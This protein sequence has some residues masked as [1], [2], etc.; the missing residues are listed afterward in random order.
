MSSTSPTTNL[1]E[2]LEV[3]VR[4]RMV[5]PGC[6][7]D[8]SQRAGRRKLT[9]SHFC[10]ENGWLS[11]IQAE[12]LEGLL[13]PQSIA[14]GYQIEGLLG[15]GGIGIVY[16]ARQPSL[17]RLVALKTISTTHLS[18]NSSGQGSIAVARFQQEA[19][20]V[21]KLKHPNIVTAYDY[22]A[23]DDR[24]FL[25]MEMVEGIDLDSFIKHAELL[26]ELTAWRIAAQVAA[27]LTH[28][29][30]FGVVHRDIKPANILATDPS[31][32]HPLP[33]GTPLVKVT[34]FGLA[35]LN[36]GTVND[37]QTRLTTVGSM[38]GTPH[39]M[40]PEQIENPD[41]GFQADIYA[42]GATVYHMLTGE[43]PLKG[44]SVMKVFVAKMSGEG[45]SLDNLPKAVGQ[46]GRD[47]L[48]AMMAHDPSQ[49][50][51]TYGE[52]LSRIGQILEDEAMVANH[53][54]SVYPS[55]REIAS[56]GE[57][58]PTL[59][60]RAEPR[61]SSNKTFWVA[62]CAA[63]LLGTA[64]LSLVP[65]GR[66]D[67]TPTPQYAAQEGFKATRSLY[68]GRSIAG[69]QGVARAPDDGEYAGMLR[70]LGTARLSIAEQL[71]GFPDPDHFCVGLQIGVGENDAMELWLETSTDG[72]ITALRV[73]K[74][75]LTLGHRASKRDEFISDAEP[76]AL[77]SSSISP[78]P[79]LRIDRDEQ[80]WLIRQSV[81]GEPP[82][83]RILLWTPIA[84]DSPTMLHL[85][86]EGEAVYFGQI[87][88]VPLK[89]S[90]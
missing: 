15:Y 45:A 65:L 22:G 69:W 47:L 42:L 59:E 25:A 31:V 54:P 17:D 29:L 40:A 56:V 76:V 64:A 20:A 63:V 75:Q 26:D 18:E 57:G 66:S 50:P 82:P 61:P 34:D 49:R 3:A 52:L 39:Y 73:G 81:P 84:G 71:R 19:Q 8:I 80:Y 68:D 6:A 4:E 38:M 33:A 86:A 41:V 10:V 85:K 51:Q 53:P 16:Q 32:G 35:R 9:P 72:S 46:P 37:Q 43:P 36:A 90:E 11:S 24:V 77:V 74:G 70:V 48:A 28:A 87:E 13:A 83:P 44:L 12:A 1:A 78:T 55:P 14:P 7:E 23:A 67:L 60:F 88:L 58:E 27:A 79:V 21:A 5:T 30:E 89:R 62:A 2:F